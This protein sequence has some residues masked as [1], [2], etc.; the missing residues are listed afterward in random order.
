MSLMRK[1]LKLLTEN[2]LSGTA[3]CQLCWSEYEEPTLPILSLQQAE[4]C[5]VQSLST[6]V[7]ILCNEL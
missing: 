3:V 6:L 2:Y 1:R 7:G 5:T 4:H